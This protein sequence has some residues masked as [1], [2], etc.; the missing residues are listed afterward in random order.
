MVSLDLHALGFDFP[1]WEALVDALIGGGMISYT[2][3]GPFK[4]VGHYQDG[5]GAGVGLV[6]FQEESGYTVPSL[7][8]TGGHRVSAY[9]IYSSLAQLDIYDENNELC[10]RLLA[11]VNDPQ[12]YPIYRFGKEGKLARFDDYQLSAAALEVTVYPS[13]ENWQAHQTPISYSDSSLSDKSEKMFIGPKFVASL[14]LFAL[15]AG[16]CK[17]EE[18]NPAAMFKGVVQQAELRTNHLTGQHWYRAEVDC[19]FP[20]VV[21]LPSETQP[22]PAPGSVI[23]GNVYLIGSTGFWNR[24]KGYR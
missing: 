2:G 15:H 9:Q 5:S 3:I 19:G 17:P 21:A 4:L 6:R 12:Q 7:I 8:G 20:I 13:V 16:D 23:D 22:A 11:S 10:Y 24:D 14:W 18:A 1:D